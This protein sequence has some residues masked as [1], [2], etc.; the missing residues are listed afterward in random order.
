MIF[1]RL[2]LLLVVCLFSACSTVPEGLNDELYIKIS[3]ETI[4]QE[5]DNDAQV[6]QKYG[7][8]QTE[9]EAFR[10][11][12]LKDPDRTQKIRE[13]LLQAVGECLGGMP[14]A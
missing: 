1:K 9:I 3:A 2:L 7:V 13:Q 12:F 6:Y 8:T 14:E 10:T 4:C 11:E 5:E